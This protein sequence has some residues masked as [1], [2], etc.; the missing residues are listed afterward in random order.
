MKLTEEQLKIIKNNERKILV[1]AGAGTGKTEILTRRILRLIEE[2]PTLSIND[3][4]II[5]FTNKA[6]DVLKERIKRIFYTKWNNEHDFEQKKRFRYELELLNSAH[7]FTIHQ[8][9]K[10]ILQDHGPLYED[11]ISINY[12]PF[13]SIRSNQLRDII[14]S[15]IE[16]WIQAKKK[17][18]TP[19]KHLDYFPIHKLIEIIETTYKHIRSKGLDLQQVIKQTRTSALQESDVAVYQIKQELLEIIE[20]THLNLFKSNYNRLD[21][22]SLLEYCAKLLQNHSSLLKEVQ[23]RYKHIFI[24]E[25]QDTSLHQAQIIK[26]ICGHSSDSPSL[27]VVGD[28]KQSIYQ[29]RGADLDSYS[30]IEEWIKKEGTVLSLTTNWRSTPEIIHY[31]NTVFDHL[32]EGEKYVFYQEHLKPG[33]N[34][35]SIDL[36]SAREWFFGKNKSEQD[37]LIAQYLKKAYEQG[38]NLNQY[39]ILV[40]YNHQLPTI[41][42]ELEKQA[43]PYQIIDSGNLYNQREIIDMYRVLKSI[44][45]ENNDIPAYEAKN[46]IFFHDQKERYQELMEEIYNQKLIFR[47]TPS[48][49]I[50][51][52]CQKTN[53]YSKCTLQ[54]KANLNKLKEK[55]RQLIKDEKIS[56]YHYIDWLSRMIISNADEPLADIST[57]EKNVVSLMTIHKA[58]GLEFPI[59]V[60]PYMDQGFSKRSLQPEIIIDQDNLSIELRYQ[61]YYDSTPIESQHYKHSL[62]KMKFHFF[63]E[64]LRV[65]YVALTRAKEKLILF[66]ISKC[67]KGKDCYQNWLLKENDE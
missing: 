6:T 32:K 3:M 46:T 11:Q 44:I 49:I 58:K 25:F 48:Q 35:K 59:V 4:A 14:H 2:D 66:G 47:Y 28:I 1:K 64:E 30:E 36:K 33:H 52:I 45:D 50:D 41:A 53:I 67:K 18:K 37:E 39:V 61:K 7:I 10:S 56:L 20:E 8:F 42:A 40:R 27:F 34:I 24:D 62:E 60:L 51:Y 16:H 17:N 23:N 63:S 55:T 22:D 19:I 15:T 43:I 54:V 12:S 57:E 26:L 29:F 31:V 21:A 13:F 38:Q 9:C 65:L 5:T